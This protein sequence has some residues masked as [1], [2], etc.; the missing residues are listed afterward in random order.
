MPDLPQIVAG[1]VWAG[2]IGSWLVYQRSAARAR[3]SPGQ[4]ACARCGVAIDPPP[5][6]SATGRSE[7][8][9]SCFSVTKRNYRAA[10]L[11]FL[12]LSVFVVALGPVVVIADYRRFGVGSAAK[13]AALLFGGTLLTGVPGW[14][15]R[16]LGRDG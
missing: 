2:L 13:A 3:V 11:F 5:L 14:F 1:L 8:C 9:S 16:R 12:G 6:L 7:L 10:S 4:G 15:L